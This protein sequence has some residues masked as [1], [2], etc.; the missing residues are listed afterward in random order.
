VAAS[1]TTYTMDEV[2]KHNTKTDCWIVVNGGVY[3]VTEF[4]DLHPGGGSMLDMVAGKD[5]SDFFNELHKEGILEEV[6]E[7]YLIGAIEE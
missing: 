3:D 2:A 4:R 7:E 5:G 1:D 6:G